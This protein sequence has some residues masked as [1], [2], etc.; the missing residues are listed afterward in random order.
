MPAELAG[1][2]EVKR[3]KASK[4]SDSDVRSVSRAK[5]DG[6]RRQKRSFT[7]LMRL[8]ERSQFTSI[9][10]I[11]ML[12]L[13]VT[14]CAS[15]ELRAQRKSMKRLEKSKEESKRIE[16]K[17]IMGPMLRNSLTRFNK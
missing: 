1:I 5:R 16:F 13:R 2:S 15:N 8:K 12:K 4:L 14:S 9:E 11:N 17:Y 7:E 6:C 10:V 3:V